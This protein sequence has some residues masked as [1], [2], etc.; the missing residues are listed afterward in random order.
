[1]FSVLS[2]RWCSVFASLIIVFMDLMPLSAAAFT[3][4]FSVEVKTDCLACRISE[5]FP[6][7]KQQLQG[8]MAWTATMQHLGKQVV[9]GLAATAS[10]NIQAPVGLKPVEQQA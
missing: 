5:Q 3:E 6:P 1:M 7:L 2:R 4:D 8:E 10:G 9:E